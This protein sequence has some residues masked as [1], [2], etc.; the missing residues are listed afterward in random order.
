MKLPFYIMG[1]AL[2][3]TC[4]VIF[5]VSGEAPRVLRS[6]YWTSPSP[7][8]LSDAERGA[9]E[10]VTPVPSM[11]VII[12]FHP[13]DEVPAEPWGG[14][15]RIGTDPCEIDLRADDYA[16]VAHPAAGSARFE[17]SLAVAQSN[18][19]HEMLHCIRGFWHPDWSA[20]EE[21]QQQLMLVTEPRCGEHEDDPVLAEHCSHNGEC[22]R[23]CRR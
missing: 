19:A 8:E 12:H 3:L 1:F 22:E 10:I 5:I 4:G 17:D 6:V 13:R 18:I 11:T 2:C 20:I 16:I 15:T 21:Q 14:Q 23:E 7:R 9:A